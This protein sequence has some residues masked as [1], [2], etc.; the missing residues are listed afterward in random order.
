[1][2]IALCLSGQMRSYRTTIKSVDRFILQPLQPDVY[3]HT[4]EETGVPKRIFECL[5]WW[6]K[7]FPR[8]VRVQLGRFFDVG[9]E[10]LNY[11]DLSIYSP[12]KI[13]IEK[14]ENYYYKSLEGNVLPE[15]INELEKG[16]KALL[17]M[18]YKSF[19]C[20][21]LMKSTRVKYDIVIRT[22]P[23]LLHTQHIDERVIKGDDCLWVG[24][25]G[26]NTLYMASDRIAV[27]APM[28]IDY[29]VSL[30]RDL[31]SYFTNI[32]EKT[33]FRQRPFGERLM[34]QHLERGRQQGKI[35][36]QYFKSGTKMQRPV[37]R[38]SFKNFNKE[39]FQDIRN[40]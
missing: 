24:N 34:K 9:S 2:R 19:A 4:W 17:P 32:D 10:S 7:R 22:R 23:D 18:C 5:P 38:L 21:E 31:Q 3:I 39:P 29:V 20:N 26:I 14:F 11:T 27:G 28:N 33:P 6:C 30:W 36:Y 40:D 13:V 16:R 12:K 35:K 8:L 15:H 37:A 1:M 25:D